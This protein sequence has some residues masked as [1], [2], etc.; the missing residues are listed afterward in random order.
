MYI[1]T[2]AYACVCM[3]VRLCMCMYVHINTPYVDACVYVTL[4][5]KFKSCQP[6][7][8][9]LIMHVIPT[10]SSEAFC[11]SNNSSASQ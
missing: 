7:F 5:N 8:T 11:M 2:Y 4:N 9:K 1:R 3:N 10:N 6:I